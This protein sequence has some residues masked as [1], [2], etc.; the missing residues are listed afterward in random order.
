MAKNPRQK[1]PLQTKK[2]LA[3]I[4]RER[5]QRRY[6]LI[7]SIVVLVL[8]VALIVYGIVEQTYLQPLQPVAVVNG[9]KVS[10]R[11]FQTQTR[12]ARYQLVSNARNT[13]Q[14]LELFGN[15]PEAL[16][17]FQGQIQQIQAQ[18][19]PTSIGQEVL[20]NLIEAELIRQEAEKRGLLVTKEELDEAVA[21]AFGYYQ[22]GTP[23]IQP[24]EKPIPTSTLNPTQKALLPPTSTPTA[25]PVI[26]PTATPVITITLTPTQIPTITQTPDPTLTPTPYTEQGFQ[27]LYDEVMANFE[28]DIQFDESDLR[29]QIETNLYREKLM[30]AVLA[31]LEVSRE[32]E[33]VWAR[34]ILVADEQTA[35]DV[36][37]QIR[38][39][40]DWNDM[41]MLYSTD[42]SNKEQGGD[43]GWFGRGAMVVEF[44]KAAFELSIGE[45]S[46]PVQTSFGWHIIQVLGHEVRTLSESEYQQLREQKFSEWLTQVRENATIDIRDYWV[47]RVPAE[48][49]LPPEI[50]QFLQQSVQ[51]IPQPTLPAASPDQ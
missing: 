15:N 43:L 28:K 21:N 11:D 46:E 35:Q 18:L 5:I 44:E 30:E 50:V 48:P 36:L 20:D 41:A 32:V 29:Y 22:N 1:Q 33:Q 42:T 3:R 51:S 26:T 24:T 8:V 40:A 31:E 38:E 37:K 49:T 23:T 34:H 2:H 17:S 19:E 14:F 16:S 4:E 10:T 13:M 47:D 7:S 25:T 12:Y 39:G 45:I 6:I 27:S 9:Q